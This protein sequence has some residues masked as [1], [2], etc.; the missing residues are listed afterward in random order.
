MMPLS[1]HQIKAI[2]DAV[3]MVEETED[4]CGEVTIMIKNHHPH[5]IRPAPN[6]K[7]PFSGTKTESQAEYRPGKEG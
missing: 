5:L 1:D 6:L 4:G 2:Q 3:R 7:M